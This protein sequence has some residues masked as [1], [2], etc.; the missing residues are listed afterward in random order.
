MEAIKNAINLLIK[1]GYLVSSEVA[2]GQK[3]L[4][5]TNKLGRFFDDMTNIQQP[6]TTAVLSQKET[7]TLKE[8]ANRAEV[9]GIVQRG[10]NRYNVNR[11]S[12]AAEKE[13]NKKVVG[14]VN[15]D[16]LIEAT[17]RY[18]A[19]KQLFPVTLTNFFIEGIWENTLKDF[20]KKKDS[21]VNQEYTGE[22]SI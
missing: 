8:F 10:A 15:M 12:L 20:M 22:R 13:F 21:G 4:M 19:D 2:G 5:I 7:I 14:K 16:L 3:F 6:D 11:I 1:E 9:P 17:K 18:Y